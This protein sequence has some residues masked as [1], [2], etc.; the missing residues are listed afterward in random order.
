MIQVTSRMLLACRCSKCYAWALRMICHH[1]LDYWTSKNHKRWSYCC[2]FNWVRRLR[3]QSRSELSQTGRKMNDGWSWRWYNNRY[4][5]RKRNL[6]RRTKGSVCWLSS[7]RDQKLNDRSSRKSD[8][9]CCQNV[10]QSHLSWSI[11]TNSHNIS[12][13]GLKH[14]WVNHSSS[15][16]TR[17]LWY[18]HDWK[19]LKTTR[20][21][22]K[23]HWRNWNWLWNN[24]PLTNLRQNQ[25]RINLHWS[26]CSTL[27]W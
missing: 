27:W 5:T 20:I 18:S 13:W 22:S 6:Q 11:E 4:T 23:F 15:F 12:K 9:Q 8:W 17:T 16:K 7:F 21:I 26:L 3:S 14:C 19:R 25:R 2:Q 24:L 1:R 10:N